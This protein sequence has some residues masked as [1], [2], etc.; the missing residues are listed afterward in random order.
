MGNSVTAL[1]YAALL[2][3]SGYRTRVVA[4]SDDVPNADLLIALHAHRSARLVAAYRA[5][6]PERPIVVVLSGTDV[7]ARRR[8]SGASLASLGAAD[9]IITLQPQAIVRLPTA[10]RARAL[11][12][13][14]SS[15]SSPSERAKRA[16]SGVRFCVLGHLRREKDPLRAAFALRYVRDNTIRVVQAG[17]ILDPRYALRI[18]RLE[19]RD[20]RYRYVGERSHGRALRLLIQ[21]DALIL[22]SRSE[23]GANVASEAIAN[24]IPV[25]A[26]R[27]DGNVGIFGRDY[28]GYYPVGSSVKLAQLMDRFTTDAAFARRLR[29]QI[30]RL[31]P[32]VAPERERRGLVDAIR[33]ALHNRDL[34]EA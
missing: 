21:S 33:L 34:R 32:A 12:V 15:P 2:R 17:G 16:G 30:R 3:S 1:R 24:G 23:G 20:A 29:R 14:Q 5:R 18:S 28:A 25:L 9:A 22:S 19:A 27:I 11:A 8:W 26:S 10:L 7:Y 31:Q 13:V 4:S 6:F